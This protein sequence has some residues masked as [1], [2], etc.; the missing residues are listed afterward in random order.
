MIG[1][2]WTVGRRAGLVDA[3]AGSALIRV[4]PRGYRDLLMLHGLTEIALLPY[5][6][7]STTDAGVILDDHGPRRLRY[8]VDG[9]SYK[10]YQ[11]AHTYE[12]NSPEGFVRALIRSDNGSDHARLLEVTVTADGVSYQV[13]AETSRFRPRRVRRQR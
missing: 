12:P 4:G 2:C 10:L 5:D 1:L 3:W 13:V 6:P 7:G 8:G 9:D 11:P